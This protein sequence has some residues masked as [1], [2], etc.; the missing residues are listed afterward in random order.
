MNKGFAD[1]ERPT[2]EVFTPS[3][4]WEWKNVTFWDCVS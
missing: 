2:V 1:Y 4:R 3:P